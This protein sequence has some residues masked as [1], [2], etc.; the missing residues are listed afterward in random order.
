MDLNMVRTSEVQ[1]VVLEQLKVGT[2]ELLPNDLM[3]TLEDA[4]V[5]PKHLL[6]K[7][8]GWMWAQRPERKII[9]TAWTRVPNTWWDHLK[10]TIAV[11]WPLFR[12][13]LNW[14]WKEIYRNIEVDLQ[15]AYPELRLLM[16]NY[17]KHLVI[18]QIVPGKEDKDGQHY[19]RWEYDEVGGVS[20]G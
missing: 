17:G 7:L 4:A 18:A 1:K 15:V 19:W 10:E 13:Y 12:P 11:K 20:K 2:S 8:R 5:L 9:G 14:E 3:L 6:F 16:P